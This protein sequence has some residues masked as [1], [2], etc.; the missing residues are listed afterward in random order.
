MALVVVARQFR[1]RREDRY[2]AVLDGVV[3]QYLDAPALVE[4]AANGEDV[5]W[6]ITKPVALLEEIEHKNASN[7]RKAVD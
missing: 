4:A 1:S 2:E 5:L 7:H 3:R 6:D